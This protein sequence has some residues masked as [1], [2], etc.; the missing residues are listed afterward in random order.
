MMVSNLIRRM[1]ERIDGFGQQA[2]YL[3]S[4]TILSQF[5][6]L[7]RDRLLAGHL[8]PTAQLD[9]YYAA[10]RVPDILF[11]TIATLVSVVSVIPHLSDYLKNGDDEGKQKAQRLMNSLFT[12]FSYTLI[13]LSV[14]FFFLMPFLSK[15]V[16]PGFDAVQRADLISLSRIMLLSPFILGVS[17]LAGSI[18]QYYRHF[19]AFAL[20]PFLYN[21]GLIIGIAVLYP[22][23]GLYGLGLGVILAALLHFSTQIR[24]LKL[25]GF[26][27]RFVRAR[28]IDWPGVKKVI[29]SSVPRTL[30]LSFSTLLFVV[31]TAIASNISEG[32]VSLLQFSHNLQ[33][34][35]LSVIGLSLSVAAFPMLSDFYSR[36]EYGAFSQG[37]ANALR[38]LFF[39]ALPITVLFI[40]L[41]T[42]I[43]RVIL[44]TNVFS[45][46]HT[47][48]V[49]AALSIFV[50][51]VVAQ[52]VILLFSRAFYAAR[53]T[54]V[55]LYINGLFAL[56]IALCII[57]LMPDYQGSWFDRRLSI[58]KASIEGRI[59][60]GDD[61]IPSRHLAK[62]GRD[63]R[64][65]GERWR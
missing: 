54:S 31:M 13:F 29:T 14:V 17:N 57:L 7:V 10:F 23:F 48:V 39:W 61:R 63:Q 64:L 9:I 45:W 51:S 19:V 44:G 12:S 38:Q 8:G 4:F 59:C 26:V 2:L 65:P 56:V 16:A 15:L 33:S 30:A 11:I 53:R 43:V 35:P 25:H 55:P 21:L 6:G 20:S 18:T 47:K 22:L 32:S 28:N 5:L 60:Q 41:R 52:S 50:I 58:R 36:R 62:C 37:L 34:V 27:P 1:T 46:Q 24:S 40:V 49:A 42:H 3:G